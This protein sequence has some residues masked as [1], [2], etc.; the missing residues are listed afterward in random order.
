M[1]PARAQAPAIL[2][3]D[4]TATYGELAGEIDWL[5]GELQRLGVRAGVRVGV[6]AARAAA[7]VA[8]TYA[9]WRLGAAAVPIGSEMKPAEIAGL[10]KTMRLAWIIADQRGGDAAIPATRAAGELAAFG[11]VLQ[12]FRRDGDTARD[13]GIAFLRFTSGT[14]GEAK[15]V[16]IS[17]E[18]I[19]ARTESANAALGIGPED[20]VLFPLSMAHHFAAT[21][22]LY[23]RVGAAIAIPRDTLAAGMLEAA[24]KAGATVIYAA[25]FQFRLLAADASGAGLGAVRLAVSTTS[26]LAPE[27]RRLFAAR[28]GIVPRQAY[29]IIECGLVSISAEGDP[30]ASVGAPLPGCAIEIVNAEEG[31]GA[32]MVQAPGMFD[33]YAAPWMP[34]NE[35]LRQGWFATGD[36]G[37]IDAAGR[38]TLLGREKD[39]IAVAGM[40]VFPQ[41]IEASINALSGVAESR[42]T[43]REHPT[44]GQVIRAEVVAAPGQV[45]PT[46]RAIRDHCRRELAD[47]KAPT[48]VRFVESIPKTATGKILRRTGNEA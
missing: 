26:A 29:G 38:L 21:V 30:D 22:S 34:S 10:A 40:K 46:A 3:P 15:G 27:T 18:A 43:G 1:A 48:E 31:R 47:Y 8:A 19:A 23:L 37:E 17:H 4:S 11:A 41:E 6:R 42:V 35:V 25:P 28:F 14:T 16:A 20:R 45:P 2:E 44:L 13:E 7:C 12:V 32:V 36:L 39:V 9:V 5:A 24:A 33:A